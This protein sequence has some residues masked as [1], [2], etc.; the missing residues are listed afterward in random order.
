MIAPKL[1]FDDKIFQKVEED[2]KGKWYTHTRATIT[3]H[4]FM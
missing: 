1:A 2:Y 4:I 3:M